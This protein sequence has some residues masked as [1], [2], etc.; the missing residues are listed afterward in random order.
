MKYNKIMMITIMLVTMIALATVVQ[1]VVDEP[2]I[3]MSITSYEPGPAQPGDTVEVWVKIENTGNGD[4][5]NLV[6][7]YKDSYPFKLLSEDERI[8]TIKKLETGSDYLINYRIRVDASASQG[9]ENIQISYTLGNY[10]DTKVIKN[11]PLQITTTDTPVTISSVK[12]DPEVL[13]PGSKSELKIGVKNLAKSST[14]RDLSVTL[15]LT[16]VVS[17]TSILIDLPFV[18]INGGSQKTI[19]KAVPG[20][21]TEFVFE[22]AAYPDAISQLYKVP[23]YLSYKDEEGTQYNK[24]LLIGIEVNAEPELLIT[25]DQTDL[26]SEKMS[27]EIALGVTNKGISDIKLLSLKL[28]DSDSYELISTNKELYLG[29]IDSDDFETARFEIELKETGTIKLPVSVSFKDALNNQYNQKYEI[30]YTVRDPPEQQGSPLPAI[31]IVIII[32]VVVVI[33]VKRNNK[34]KRQ[35][36]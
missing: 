8:T 18:P 36:K 25:L 2:T 31:I 27:G 13:S 4:A 15:G 9:S 7:E 17:S 11:L 21:T 12:L 10:A 34:K 24:T 35:N 16:P 29:N 26:N 33:L 5:N 3:E 14:V 19:D 32:V 28:G 20:Q 6:I 30:E 22:I 23:V 1:A